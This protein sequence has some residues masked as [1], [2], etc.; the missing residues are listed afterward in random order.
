MESKIKPLYKFKSGEQW[1]CHL[2]M[3]TFLK[4]AAKNTF[5]CS[6]Y[7]LVMMSN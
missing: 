4:D 3:K 7:Q 5:K 2:L 6:G 1:L